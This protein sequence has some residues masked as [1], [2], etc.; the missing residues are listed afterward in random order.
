MCGASLDPGAH[1]TEACPHG[2]RRLRV[3]DD[4]VD[5]LF[6]VLKAVGATIIIKRYAPQLYNQL[7]ERYKE[8]V[9]DL[10]LHFAG[11]SE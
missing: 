8:A 2:G 9:L 1:H 7:T 10:C 3:H 6:K 5:G 11:T 4:A